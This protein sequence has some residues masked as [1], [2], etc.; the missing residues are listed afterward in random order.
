MSLSLAELKRYRAD[1]RFIL[2]DPHTG[3][4][5]S[6]RQ[7]DAKVRE[8]ERLEQ[9]E[10]SQSQVTEEDDK[11]GKVLNHWKPL[12]I[13]PTEE[14]FHDALNKVDYEA[15]FPPPAEPNWE[16][17][18]VS[19]M[20]DLVSRFKQ[21]WRYRFLPQYFA[22]KRAEA[23]FPALWSTRQ[24]QFQEVYEAACRQH[25][26]RIERERNDWNQQ[27][28]TRVISLQKLLAAD[29]EEIHSVAGELIGNLDFPFDTNCDV[30][31]QD[32]ASIYLHVDLPEIEDVIPT[33][34]RKVLKSGEI[35]EVRRTRRD[36]N[37]DYTHIVIGQC[38]YLA[39]L[40]F[41]CLPTVETVDVAAY[42]QRTRRRESDS[43]DTYI[44]DIPF[45][46]D[47]VSE[48]G[49]KPERIAAFVAR[50]GGRMDLR[51]DGSLGRI[52]PPSWLTNEDL[53]KLTV[54]DQ[55]DAR[56]S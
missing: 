24:A 25:Q 9:V 12:P 18:R 35:K 23:D 13:I 55:E 11:Y 33:K 19:L 39:A 50:Q 38:I 43:I 16:L 48:F 42:T 28:E 41:S 45:K 51:G 31:L 2:C 1:G 7:L 36:Q 52:E 3:R 30:F 47:G 20:S 27:E 10:K 4:K 15:D 49:Q 56:P 22:R 17:H 21:Q 46:R 54:A 40:L 32:A 6:Q 5:L 29:L 34:D 53:G 8:L 37:E 26:A 44:L 14:E